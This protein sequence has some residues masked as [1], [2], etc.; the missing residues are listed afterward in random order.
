MDKAWFYPNDAA[1]LFCSLFIKITKSILCGWDFIFKS[2]L[3]LCF[4]NSATKIINTTIGKLEH[5]PKF[6]Y[7]QNH[8]QTLHFW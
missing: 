7:Y 1:K 3:L 4:A 6:N 5:D 2:I 8:E